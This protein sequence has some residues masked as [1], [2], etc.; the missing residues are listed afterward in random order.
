MT[1]DYGVRLIVRVRY[2]RLTVFSRRP[3]KVKALAQEA[4]RMDKGSASLNRSLSEICDSK[5]KNCFSP[6]CPVVVAYR[7]GSRPEQLVLVST[8][9]GM[10]LTK[11]FGQSCAIRAFDVLAKPQDRLQDLSV[12]V[13]V[14]V[15]NSALCA[16]LSQQQTTHLYEAR[17]PV[18]VDHPDGRPCLLVRSWQIYHLRQGT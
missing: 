6:T 9:N 17:S 13:E 15:W 4:H 8:L 16:I 1:F 2:V 11:A 18:F 12:K 14:V 3:S 5:V 7:A 10:L